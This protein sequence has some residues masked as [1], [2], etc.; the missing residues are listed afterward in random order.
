MENV[1][2]YLLNKLKKTGAKNI[3]AFLKKVEKCDTTPF[4]S[5]KIFQIFKMAG[6]IRCALYGE[7]TLACCIVY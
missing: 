7:N 5:V 2:Y 3:H 6:K 4:L 1:P